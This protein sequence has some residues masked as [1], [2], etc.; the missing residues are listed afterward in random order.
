MYDDDDENDSDDGRP[1]GRRLFVASFVNMIVP[2]NDSATILQNMTATLLHD[3]F[4]MLHPPPFF[5]I[6]EERVDDDGGGDNDID[7]DTDIGDEDDNDDAD[8]SVGELND[9]LS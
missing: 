2:I 8:V 1:C 7:I 3:L 6:D 4:F 5:I 9:A